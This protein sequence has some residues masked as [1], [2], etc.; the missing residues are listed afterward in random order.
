M[1]QIKKKNGI[2][3]RENRL[4][5]LSV[6]IYHVRFNYNFLVGFSMS[7]DQ[8]RRIIENLS[9]YIKDKLNVDVPKKRLRDIYSDKIK[10]LGFDIH[11]ISVG[12]S[13][14]FQNKKL[15]VRK[16]HQNKHLKE[17]VRDYIRFLKAVE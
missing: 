10:F 2:L 6:Q 16:R 5:E 7:K 17:G 9:K 13:K 12:L 11:R 3:L 15:E 1:L 14:P 8:S 4:E